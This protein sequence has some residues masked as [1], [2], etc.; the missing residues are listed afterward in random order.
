MK[1]TPIDRNLYPDEKR[2][3]ITGTSTDQML[4]YHKAPKEVKSKGE[5]LNSRN[6]PRDSY[7]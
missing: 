2:A 4:K 1:E 7:F 3:H 5:Y 6:V